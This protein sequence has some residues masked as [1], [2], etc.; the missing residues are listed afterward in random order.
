M[1]VTHS[2]SLTTLRKR[3]KR[4]KTLARIEKEAEKTAKKGAG[5][6]SANK[7]RN[8]TAGEKGNG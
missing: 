1:T 6:G 3:Q 4:K 2:K 7:S 5:S 8:E